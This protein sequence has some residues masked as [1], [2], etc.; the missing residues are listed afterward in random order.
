MFRS[1]MSLSSWSRKNSLKRI[2]L[3]KDSRS[4][5]SW[6][7]SNFVGVGQNDSPLDSKMFSS[8]VKSSPERF[9]TILEVSSGDLIIH[10]LLF[11][12]LLNFRLFFCISHRLEGRI[13]RECNFLC[14]FSSSLCLFLMYC[15]R[16]FSKT[17]FILDCPSVRTAVFASLVM[18]CSRCC[19]HFLWNFSRPRAYQ[20]KPA[21][22]FVPIDDVIVVTWSYQ[23][24]M[25]HVA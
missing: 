5:K 20:S 18:Y 7:S 17:P 16:V 10:F 9:T 13:C 24:G 3:K 21:K 12:C 2:H 4:S 1:L 11:L 6:F 25:V 14:C 19:S 15:V 8:S 22:Q 23:A